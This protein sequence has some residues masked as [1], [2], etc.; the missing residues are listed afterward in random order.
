MA[1]IAAPTY[2]RLAATD[3]WSVADVVCTAGP[4]DRP[5]EEQHDRTS[6]GVVLSGTFEYRSSTGDATMVPGSL[7][8]GN[9][10]DHFLCRRDHG[11]G[12]RC[13][14]FSYSPEFF[15]R[16]AH[17][18]GVRTSGFSV[19]RLPP[20]RAVA[21]PIA[22]AAALLQS[23]D[24]NWFA[25]EELAIDLAAK[26][27]SL[28]RRRGRSR[29][30]ADA[31]AIARVTRVVRALEREVD[32]PQSIRGLARLAR[33]S[34]FHFIRTFQHVTGTTPHQYRLRQR[35]R[36]AAERLRSG[37]A[38]VVDIALDC[39]FGDVSNFTRTFRAEFGV[40]PLQFRR[41]RGENRGDQGR[42]PDRPGDV[43]AGN[44]SRVS[45]GDR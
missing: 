10:G 11:C 16:L 9:C 7:L 33:L 42:S 40:T 44:R 18:C 29:T 3:D 15:E 38:R 35:L 19:P 27:L 4:H 26:T 2:R 17:D 1:K 28:D 41:R 32:A 30:L 37:D 25:F 24:R 34:P 45:R 36:R 22:R 8:L 39:G 5:F 43:E 14:A 6:I 12:D 20:I 21:G 31:G 13:V 23:P